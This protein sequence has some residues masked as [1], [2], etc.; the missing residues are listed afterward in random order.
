MKARHAG[1]IRVGIR[2]G[3]LQNAGVRRPRLRFVSRLTMR[4]YQKTIRRS[5]RW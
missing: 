2:I 3:Q 1:E 5:G 4:A